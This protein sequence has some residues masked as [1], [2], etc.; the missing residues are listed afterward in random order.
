MARVFLI[1]GT[2]THSA[3]PFLSQP[4]G[5]LSIAAVLRQQGHQVAVHDCKLDLQ[6]LPAR[7]VHFEPDV[8]GIRTL[9][10]YLKVLEYLAAMIHRLLPGIPLVLGGPHANADPE[11]ALRLAGADCA[12]LGEGELTF[13]ELLGPLLD[14]TPLHGVDGVAFLDDEEFVRTTPRQPIQ[15]L[16]SLPMPA[17]DLV[18]MELYFSLHHAGTAPSGRT[19]TIFTS[20][21]CPFRCAFCHNIF[22]KRFRARGS[23]AVLEEI[24][25]LHRTYGIEEFEIHDDAF[26]TDLQRL[27]RI[28]HGLQQDN[29]NILLA[30]PNGLRGD[31]LPR[32]ALIDLRLAGTHHIALSPETASP[33]L[34]KML[35]KGIAL[36]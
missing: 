22:G 12:V 3:S 32:E 28:C 30:F 16:D 23:E 8:V 7:L 10:P 27:D 31:R 20:R 17:W 11:H 6:S 36:I 4:V 29:Q 18:P 19:V 2:V 33:R 24:R 1:D 5:L 34:Q 21:G 14:R 13:P 25:W 26:N 15:D 9:S 35:G